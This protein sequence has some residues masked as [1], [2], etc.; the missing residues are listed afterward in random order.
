MPTEQETK[1]KSAFELLGFSKTLEVIKEEIRDLYLS[2]GVPWVVGY[3]GGKDST[4]TLQ[5]IWLAL[6]EL[7]ADQRSKPVHVIATDTLVENPVVAAWVN[8]SLGRM[9]EAAKQQQL[10]IHPHR[11][12]P[13]ISN[14]FWVN[15][16]GKGYPAPRQKFRWCTERLKIQPSNEFILSVVRENG[17]AILTLGTRKSE[18]AAR[19]RNMAHH[20]KKAVRDRL[21][22]NASLTNCMIYTP[23]EDWSNDDVWMFL[24]RVANCWG[25]SNKDLMGM[26][27]GASEDGECPLVVDT[28]TPS[29]GNSRFGCWVCTLVDED[30]SMGAMIRN[31]SEKEWMLPLLD[32]RNELD[33]RSEEAR[34]RDRQRRD[35]RRITGQLTYYKNVN[36]EPQLVPGPYVQDAREYW[37][38]RVLQ[39]QREVRQR[40][41]EGLEDIELISH[42]ELEEIRRIWVV[43]KHEIEDRLPKIYAEEVGEPYP[44]EPIDDN[45]IF[46]SDTLDVLR[47]ACGG[48]NLHFEMVR[49]LLDAERRY[50]TM[51]SRRGLF[52]ELEQIIRR[53]FYEDEADAMSRAEAKHAAKQGQFVHQ[54]DNG[55]HPEVATDAAT[56]LFEVGAVNDS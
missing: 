36:G 53:C 47:E 39:A 29:C 19:G 56:P 52:G 44:G 26:Y 30:K 9:Q 51:A 12:T 49:N 17:E 43:E 10:P 32:L 27:R 6:T 4:A 22:P 13:Q 21:T 23:I 46:D 15:L 18:S 5:L 55:L 38:R 25:H 54:D 3:S 33:F 40:A 34:Q 28:S 48:D 42:E 50:R 14:T 35:F 2:D 1:P 45:L 7:P 37:L 8:R 41:P 24:M 16:I 31:D 11:L 20:E